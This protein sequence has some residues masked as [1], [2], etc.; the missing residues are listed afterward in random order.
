MSVLTLPG[1]G[2]GEDYDKSYQDDGGGAAA[3][4]GIGHGAGSVASGH[5]LNSYA[6]FHHDIVLNSHYY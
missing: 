6:L 1:Y 5:D 3:V 2:Y 4:S